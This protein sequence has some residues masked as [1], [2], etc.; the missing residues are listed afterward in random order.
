MLFSFCRRSVWV[1]DRGGRHIEP[2]RLLL[3]LSVPCPTWVCFHIHLE[4]NDFSF[5]SFLC[6][7]A[8]VDLR[9]L[10]L[11][12]TLKTWA[13]QARLLSLCLKWR[14][15]SVSR[16][17]RLPLSFPSSCSLWQK[18]AL[19]D[20]SEPSLSSSPYSCWGAFVCAGITKE[21]GLFLTAVTACWWILVHNTRP[22]LQ[23]ICGGHKINNC[24]ESEQQNELK[25]PPL[26]KPGL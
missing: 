14:Y 5:P 3:E 15:F 19:L 1:T 2:S 20:I 17:A 13:L 10:R 9:L 12:D 24:E 7:S 11:R 22:G 25:S 6:R 4:R 26:H 23:L 21:S 16:A 8:S 18:T